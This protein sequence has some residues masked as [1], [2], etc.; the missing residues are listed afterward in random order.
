MQPGPPTLP[1]AI[2]FTGFGHRLDPWRRLRLPGWRLGVVE[3]PIER[4]PDD[5]WTLGALVPQIDALW[6]EAPR[7]AL[8]SFSFGGAG[9]TAVA[10]AIAEANAGVEEGASARPVLAAPILAAPDF[11]AYVAPVQWA[12]APWSVLKKIPARKRLSVLKNFARGGAA[13][14]GPLAARLGNPAVRDFVNVVERYVGWDF[15]AYYLPY[16]DW[17]DS[18]KRTLRA[19]QSHPWP[20]LLVGADRDNVIPAAPMPTE[21]AR[22]APDVEYVEVEGVH[23]NAL[24][25]AAGEIRAWA[26]RAPAGELHS[27][28]PR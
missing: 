6:R 23:Y 1:T 27:R 18:T 22:Y 16:L 24:D 10:N 20:T 19:W 5:P 12:R 21:A 8:L 4:P 3:F 9:A 17:I 14:L 15:V 13:V 11:A 28:G 2:A 7:R 26:A 25:R